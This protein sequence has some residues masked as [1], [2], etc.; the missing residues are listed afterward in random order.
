MLKK[1]ESRGAVNDIFRLINSGQVELAKT[2]CR[3]YLD[4]HPDDINVL[5]LL[6]AILLKLG[7]PED[8]KPILEKTIGL[9]PS[10]AKPHE[11]LG[12]L[13][14]QAGET[15]KAVGCFQDAIRLDGRQASAYSGLAKA[16]ARLGD[17]EAADEAHQEYLKLSPVP[18]ALEQAERL[19]ASGQADRATKICDDISKQHPNNTEVLRLLARIATEEGRHVFAEGFAE[20]NHQALGQ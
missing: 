11:D 16:L 13:Y 5:G 8:A 2:R 15:K 12:M 6:G 4:N 18:R 3:S 17:N 9:E 10:F 7:R 20:E 1:G 14:L 19:L